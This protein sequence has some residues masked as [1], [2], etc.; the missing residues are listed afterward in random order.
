VY[1]DISRCIGKFGP[2]LELGGDGDYIA[3]D[4]YPAF[5]TIADDART[6]SA[7]I[8]PRSLPGYPYAYILSQGKAGAFDYHLRLSSG[9]LQAGN[10]DGAKTCHPD[11]LAAGQW[12]HVAVVFSS[13]GAIGYIN[14]KAGILVDRKTKTSLSN[15]SFE[16]GRLVTGTGYFNGLIDHMMVYNRVL[17]LTEIRLLYR[18]PFCMFCRRGRAQLL[19]RPRSY[20]NLW[21][22]GLPRIDRQW[23]RDVL[24]NATTSNA[25]M[26]GTVMTGGWFWIRRSG[27]TALFRGPSMSQIDLANVLKV[28]DARATE[29]SVPSYVRHQPGQRYYYVAR[30]FNGCGYLERTLH[31]AVSLS[32]D[33]QGQLVPSE[34]NGV[35][36]AGVECVDDGTVR[37]SWSYCPLEQN[38]QPSMFNIYWD[39]RSGQI[40][41]GSPWTTIEYQG[42]GAYSYQSGALEKGRYLFEIRVA[43][44]HG[45]EGDSSPQLWIELDLAAPPDAPVLCAESI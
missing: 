16:I 38:S 20:I 41:Y 32:F 44:Q 39:N 31:S 40:D 30:R 36:G 10:T 45:I 7:W 26:L 37:L 23:L 5:D 3:R 4:A 1:G 27:C 35:F 2:A 21:P 18:A 17:S 14:G 42:R 43:D 15:N 13:A 8:Y 6:I 33:E 19:P 22:G 12:Y 29:I 34:P 28:D 9:Y 24:L 25:F 11:A